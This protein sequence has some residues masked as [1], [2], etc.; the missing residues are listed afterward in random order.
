[1]RK[2]SLAQKIAAT[3]TVFALLACLALALSANFMLRRYLVHSAQGELYRV[4][5]TVAGP[6]DM[7]MPWQGAMRFRAAHRMVGAELVWVSAQGRILGSSS[8]AFPRGAFVDVPLKDLSHMTRAERWRLQTDEHVYAVAEIAA[9]RG[10]IVAVAPLRELRAVTASIM[11]IFIPISVVVVLA[12]TLLG[13]F[14]TSKISKPVRSLADAAHKIAQGDFRAVARLTGDDEIAE[15]SHALHAMALQL[16]AGEEAQREFVQ[17]ASHELKTPLMNIQGYAEALKD[18]IYSG[19]EA[20]QCLDVISR[21]TVRMQ[22]LVN[23]MIYLST[24][25]ARPERLVKEDV[26]LRDLFSAAG[27]S[28][29]GLAIEA[30]S[31][32]VVVEPPDVMLSGDFDKLVRALT[33]LIANAT[34]Y[35]RQRIELSANL[36]GSM[37]DIIIRDDGPGLD[38]ALGD[39]AFERFSRGQDGQTGL[40]LA[41]VKAIVLSHGGSAGVVNDQGAV[42]TVTLPIVGKKAQS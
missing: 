39:Q 40:G 20:A 25:T 38:P 32:L 13:S 19:S 36:R 41:I 10:F 27:E 26:P 17:N 15:L 11:S 22:K 16:Q 5:V 28:T 8:A 35:A 14:W 2:F 29:R 18:G 4:A 30:G 12:G 6:L 7:P 34:R 21:E 24:I 3:N 1:M 37:V 31:E 33:N 9:G 23:D 42:F